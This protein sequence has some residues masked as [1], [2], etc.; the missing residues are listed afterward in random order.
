MG[1]DPNLNPD[2]GHFFTDILKFFNKKIIFKFFV[3]FFFSHIFILKLGEPLRN[4]EI[5]IISV[6]SKI[7]L[8][9]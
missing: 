5:F 9:F 1:P 4:K 2:P 6:F 7:R 3:R 8:G